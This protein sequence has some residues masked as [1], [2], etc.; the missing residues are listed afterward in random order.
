MIRSG[1]LGTDGESGALRWLHLSDFHFEVGERWD[2]RATLRSLLRHL[3]ELKQQDLAP[4]LVCVTGDVARRGGRHDFQQAERFFKEL[5]TT[6]ELDPAERFFLVPGNHD[7]NRRA[8]GPADDFILDRLKDQEAIERVFADARTMD[9]LGRRLEEF[10]AFTERLLGLARGWRSGRPW[11]VDVRE[12][13]GLPVGILQLNSAW[14]SGPNDA[15]GTLLV[16]E[17]QLREALEEASDAF[18]RIALV[19]HPI[20]DLR[21]FD[22]ERLEGLVSSPDGVHVLLR[23]HLHRSRSMTIGSPGGLLIELAA[24]AVYPGGQLSEAVSPDRD[25]SDAGPGAGA[26]FPLQQ[27]RTGI[28]GPGY[29]G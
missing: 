22:R 23:G 8:I 11:R 18:L 15:Q 12:I 24:G 3:G 6:L 1:Y 27:R 14:A 13:R 10:Y 2:R 5:A 29:R 28:L 9:L 21:D 20:A 19:H 4:D 26:F 16:G 25:G 7:V 17:A